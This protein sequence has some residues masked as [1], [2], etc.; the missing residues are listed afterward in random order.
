MRYLS[1]LAS[2]SD[3]AAGLSLVG[4]LLLASGIV[5]GRV[6]VTL[7]EGRQEQLRMQA[8]VMAGGG[9]PFRE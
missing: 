1:D 2:R 8:I 3:A 6:L 4:I 7:R 5:G 9:G